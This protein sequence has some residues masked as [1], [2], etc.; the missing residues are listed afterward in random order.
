MNLSIKSKAE[1]KTLGEGGR[2]LAEVLREV[3]QAVASG[4]SAGEIDRLAERLIRAAGGEPSFKGYNPYG[5]KTPYPASICVSVNDAVVHAIPPKTQ[6][7]QDGDVVSLDIGMWWPGK[8]LRIKNKELSGVRPMATDMA[9]TVGVGAISKTAEKLIRVTRES[10]DLGIKEVKAGATIGD[11]GA[12]IQAHIENHGFGVVRD[13]AGHGVG[14]KV[15]EDP[16]VPNF[17]ERGK[18][19]VLKEGMVIA[20]EPMAT[21][22]TWRVRLDPDEWTFRTADGK[23]AAH[24]EHTVVVTKDGHQVITG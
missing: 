18:G 3:S 15:H 22:G 5:A 17:G 20:I 13:L 16:F 4:V 12:A 1:I 11:I 7:F 24:F 6:I 2:R 9:I 21:E 19:L 23:L 10:L 14:Y 8:E